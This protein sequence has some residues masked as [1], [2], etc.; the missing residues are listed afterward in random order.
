MVS[1]M[2]TLAA[3]AAIAGMATTG[4]CVSQTFET[5]ENEYFNASNN[6]PATADPL[7]E[8]NLY[9]PIYYEPNDI[10]FYRLTVSSVPSTL[11]IFVDGVDW[12]G[13]LGDPEA[14]IQNAAGAILAY[15]DDIASDVLDCILGCTFTEPGDY[16]VVVQHSRKSL[17][18]YNHSNYYLTGTF[19]FGDVRPP[20][21]PGPAGA[22]SANRLRQD[23][24]RSALVTWNAAA[25]DATPGEHLRYNVYCSTDGATVFQGP[26]AA[27]FVGA[28][29]GRIDG[30]EPGTEY[31]IGVR[32]EDLEG[33]EETNPSIV[34]ITLSELAA[35]ERT[36][37]M[38]Y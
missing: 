26:P 2:T 16:F 4:W 28:T 7:L 20:G 9:P 3:V 6:T 30:L 38:L 35:V 21:Y 19:R 14:W 32:A 1:R 27:A 24:L 8:Q 13:G 22:A 29:S 12:G 37:W 11:S 15:H 23:G 17:Y 10:D 31:W 33:N 34:P 36:R 18:D 25:D 5:F